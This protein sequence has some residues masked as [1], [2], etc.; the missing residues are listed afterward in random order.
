MVISKLS[1]VY[2]ERL[3]QEVL[4]FCKALA[5]LQSLGLHLINLATHFDYWN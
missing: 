2:I 3:I 4:V 1:Y 5:N